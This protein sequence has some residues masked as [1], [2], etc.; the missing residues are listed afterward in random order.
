MPTYSKPTSKP[1]SNA[2]STPKNSV[3]LKTTSLP[4]DIKVIPQFIIRKKRPTLKRMHYSPKT[5]T[6]MVE[7]GL[8]TADRRRQERDTYRK[9]CLL[10]TSPSP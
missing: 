1:R 5:A 6:K 7:E 8:R 3:I 9:T 10:Y 4:N 2:K